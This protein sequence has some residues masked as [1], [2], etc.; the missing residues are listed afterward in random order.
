[1]PPVTKSLIPS[2][3]SKAEASETQCQRLYNM[4]KEKLCTDKIAISVKGASVT[5]FGYSTHTNLVHLPREPLPLIDFC[6]TGYEHYEV[7]VDFTQ[8]HLDSKEQMT[9]VDFLVELSDIWASMLIKIPE[10][11]KEA[12]EMFEKAL[13]LLHSTYSIK[14]LGDISY[15]DK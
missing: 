9:R 15:L 6:P 4:F 7:K 10:S 2:V 8:D 11:S 14:E 13:N 3:I 1:M 5:S 12:R